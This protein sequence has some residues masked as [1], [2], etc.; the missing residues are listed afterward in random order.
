MPRRPSQ[1]PRRRR[2]PFVPFV[3]GT[4]VPVPNLPEA[5]TLRE[6]GLP[7]TDAEFTHVRTAMAL[8]RASRQ[9]HL[10]YAGWKVIGLALAIG[11]TRAKQ[12]ARGEVNSRGPYGVAIRQ[13]LNATGFAFLDQTTRWAL[14]EWIRNLEEVD[15][16][17]NALRADDQIHVNHPVKV[18]QRFQDDNRSPVA[19]RSR[20]RSQSAN[21]TRRRDYPTLLEEIQALQN[22]LED[23]ERRNSDL[24]M[25]MT[26]LL[27]SVST[28][29]IQ[30]LPDE[31]LRKVFA[32]LTRATQDLLHE[33]L[34]EQ[35]EGR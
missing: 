19:Q 27:E 8:H 23:M 24:E 4:L 14:R 32:K 9:P 6:L 2:Q 33:R 18:W 35:E 11:E 29:A 21:T 1:S 3:D 13:F 28:E 22:V 15:A 5:T 20:Q 30:R 17:Y 31:L 26:D 34:F 12:H 16:W 7:F 25:M 10:T